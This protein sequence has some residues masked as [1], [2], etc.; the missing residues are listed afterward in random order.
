MKEINIVM[1]TTIEEWAEVTECIKRNV[2]M[3]GKPYGEY[4]K[5]PVCGKFVGKEEKYCAHCGQRV[6]FVD[7]N[8]I[9][10]EEMA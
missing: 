8:N 6:E 9:P 10:F 2:P 3:K 5:C 4:N 1:P 7:P